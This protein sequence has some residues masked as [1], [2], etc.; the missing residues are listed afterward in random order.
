[1]D[2]SRYI[3]LLTNLRGVLYFEEP[4]ETEKLKWVVK[5]HKY[6]NVGISASLFEAC[7][8]SLKTKLKKKPFAQ[9]PYPTE[10]I[11]TLCE[12][13]PKNSK[14]KIAFENIVLASCYLSPLIILGDHSLTHLSKYISWQLKSTETLPE[15]ELKRHLRI[16][17]YVVLDFHTKT[18][19]EFMKTIRAN[20]IADRLGTLYEKRLKL[21]KEDGEKRFWRLKKKTNEGKP[22]VLYFDFLPAFK[23]AFE[24]NLLTDKVLKDQNLGI[25]FSITC[26][27]VL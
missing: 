16:A 25:A 3:S 9:L 23:D 15:L 7:D 20:N 4:L 13:L 2:L 8:P 17:R 21:A 18:C 12:T 27:F 22:V 26:G 24:N 19:E 5:T 1:V 14:E 6:R 10:G 11:K